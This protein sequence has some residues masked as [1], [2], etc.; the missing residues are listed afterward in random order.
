VKILVEWI[1]ALVSCGRL[2]LFLCVK[3]IFLFILK[4]LH[5]L[6]SKDCILYRQASQLIEV[7]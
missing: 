2:N 4:E 6:E 5:I 3:V 7:R 1:S